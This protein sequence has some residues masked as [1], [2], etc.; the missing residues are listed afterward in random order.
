MVH[1]IILVRPLA[2]VGGAPASAPFPGAWL[3]FVAPTQ[4]RGHFQARSQASMIY[5]SDM[6]AWLLGHSPSMLWFCVIPMRQSTR[7]AYPAHR[8]MPPPVPGT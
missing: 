8:S 7:V 2:R 1:Y 5:S 3:G 6:S 4:Q